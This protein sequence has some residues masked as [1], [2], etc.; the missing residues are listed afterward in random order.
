VDAAL[1]LVE[2]CITI[3]SHG[4]Q[5]DR[6]IETQKYSFTG[7]SGVKLA[8]TRREPGPKEYVILCALASKADLPARLRISVPSEITTYGA[9]FN[10]HDIDLPVLPAP[11]Q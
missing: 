9:W 11:L 2:P 6:C 4:C 10:F 1:G 8:I 7:P 5:V 3:F